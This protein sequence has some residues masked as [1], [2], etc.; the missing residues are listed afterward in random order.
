MKQPV[1]RY[2]LHKIQDGEK[3][4]ENAG[5]NISYPN[6]TKIRVS[7][8]RFSEATQAKTANHCKKKHSLE[9]QNL[10]KDSKE[11]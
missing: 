7:P 8:G 1:S 3:H 6:D 2:K 10:C 4:T 5:E 9:F 11:K